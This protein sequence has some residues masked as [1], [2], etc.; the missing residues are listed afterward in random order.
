[1][2]DEGRFGG[3]GE[4]LA[5]ID[6]D[7][8]RLRRRS[9]AANWWFFPTVSACFALVV[10]GPA[11]E[12]ADLGVQGFWWTPAILCAIA[13]VSYLQRW[14]TGVVVRLAPHAPSILVAAITVVVVVGLYFAA[15]MAERFAFTHLTGPFP[16]LAF[17]SA[18]AGFALLDRLGTFERPRAR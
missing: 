4:A 15:L 2:R 10:A 18:M 9:R 12:R 6:A 14:Q 1:M 3:A 8:D 16:F 7:R 11:L 5:A 17:I 13:G